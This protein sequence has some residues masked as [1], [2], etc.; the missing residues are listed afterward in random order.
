MKTYTVHI[1]PDYETGEVIYA[2]LSKEKALSFANKRTVENATVYT[3]VR[4]DCVETLRY[5]FGILK[6]TFKL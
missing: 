5:E 6:I 2:G 4:G 1:Y 3:F